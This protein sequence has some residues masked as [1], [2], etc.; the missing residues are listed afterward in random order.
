VP[1]RVVITT[2]CATIAAVGL[3]FSGAVAL[4]PIH[5]NAAQAQVAHAAAKPVAAKTA[6]L[7]A[8]ITPAIGNIPA[9][10]AY[11][12]VCQNTPADPGC[13]SD[14]INALDNA[15]H[16]MGLPPYA[17]PADFTTLP[18]PQQLIIL[19][20]SDRAMYGLAPIVGLNGT[21]NSAA[22]AAANSP[23]PL[24]P[25]GPSSVENVRMT[26][27]ASNWAGGWSSALY[28]YYNWMYND[29]PGSSNMDCPTAAA[30]GCWGHRLGTLT[31]FG[32]AFV[33]MGVGIG[34]YNGGTTFTEL[35]EGLRSSVSLSYTAPPVLSPMLQ[36]VTGDIDGDGRADLITTEMD[37]SL[38]YFHNNGGSTPFGAGVKIG[39][40]GWGIFD[41]IGL[42][43]VNKD[44]RADIIARTA[45]GRLFAYLNQ[46]PAA[47]FTSA[48]L[49]GQYGWQMFNWIGLADVNG[50]GYADIVARTSGGALY[51]YENNKSGLPFG[52]AAVIGLYGWNMFD[53]ISVADVS[54]DGHADV[55]ARTP[56]GALYYY[57]NNPTAAVP[58]GGA[59]LI[60]LFG[61]QV[62]DHIVVGCLSG[63]RQ[64]DLLARQFNGSWLQYT[65]TGL[66][67]PY[68]A[69]SPIGVVG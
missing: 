48:T 40:Y 23:T 34:S 51:Y 46:G 10:P 20:N 14:A 53:S 49:I 25:T 64:A 67:S 18:A 5:L 24:D 63:G 7:S 13:Q 3:A 28:V 12:W 42:A 69:A 44:N 6:V 60:G 1:T 26:A 58:Y 36:S 16:V 17:L 9:S 56:A 27:W 57:V 22:Q 52:A 29:G 2:L 66:A 47:P 59:A 11:G 45:D 35:F 4:G 21:L 54:G 30:A 55:I 41:W 33:A 43:D 68:T 61:W 39:L 8:A 50:D 19:A 31:N 37:G 62:F 32:S 38:W 15:R 65:N